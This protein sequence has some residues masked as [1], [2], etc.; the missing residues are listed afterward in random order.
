MDKY[1]K[2][3]ISIYNNKKN[4]DFHGNEIPED[5]KRCAVLSVILLDS[6]VA[7]DKKYHPQISQIECSKK[8][9]ENKFY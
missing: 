8:E 7:V 4:T 3:K 1:I 5:N 6:F 2:I 9:N